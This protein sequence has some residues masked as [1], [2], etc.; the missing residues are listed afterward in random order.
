MLISDH[1]EQIFE[2]STTIHGHTGRYQIPMQRFMDISFPKTNRQSEDQ[3]PGKTFPRGFPLNKDG[4]S[5]PQSF[6]E[7]ENIW[8]ELTRKYGRNF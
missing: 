4:V 3:S 8:A 5:F 6:L 1:G 2:R 7:L